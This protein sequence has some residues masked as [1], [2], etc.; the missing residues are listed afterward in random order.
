MDLLTFNYEWYRL[1]CSIKDCD[2]IHKFVRKI[3]KNGYYLPADREIFLPLYA[4]NE[5]AGYRAKKII[6]YDE[7][8]NKGFEVLRDKKER[9]KIF[10]EFRIIKK[11][12]RKQYD[13]VDDAY[14]KQY[15][16][17]ISREFWNQ[18]L[19]LKE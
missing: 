1:C 15:G 2:K 12:I 5:E 8:T 4:S 3:T 11:K 10:K 13:L 6:Y 7:I 17:L 9:K 19:E 14:K 16:D 18:Y